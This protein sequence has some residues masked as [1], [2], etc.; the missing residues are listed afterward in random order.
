MVK[1]SRARRP[2]R[3]A[4]PKKS[5]RPDQPTLNP[6]R[7]RWALSR[8]VDPTHPSSL[9]LPRPRHHLDHEPRPPPLARRLPAVE[10]RA[11]SLPAYDLAPLPFPTTLVD[12]M[13]L[14]MSSSDLSCHTSR[15][16]PRLRRKPFLCR[17][18][19]LVGYGRCCGLLGRPYRARLPYE[20]V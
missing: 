5:R 17:R 10:P 2:R 6:P 12:R 19:S 7:P 15:F 9:G 8:S 13:I 18:A 20:I 14:E 11:P 1:R 3:W 4:P 16:T